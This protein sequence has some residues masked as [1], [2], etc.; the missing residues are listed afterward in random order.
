[1]RRDIRAARERGASVMYIYGA[2]LIK[3]GA[4]QLLDTLMVDGWITPRHQ[5]RRRD[6]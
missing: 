2:H 4:H 3:N 1:M 6:S 5:R